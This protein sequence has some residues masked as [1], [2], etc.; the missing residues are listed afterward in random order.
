MNQ[1]SNLFFL[2]IVPVVIF[3]RAAALRLSYQTRTS[4]RGDSEKSLLFVIVEREILFVSW[5]QTFFGY[6][7]GTHYIIQQKIV[8]TL[9]SLGIWSGRDAPVMGKIKAFK[10]SWKVSRSWRGDKRKH[11]E[12]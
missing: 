11:G 1:K 4:G 5:C 9:N 10:S 12:S 8:Q 6:I 2:F 7:L 3:V